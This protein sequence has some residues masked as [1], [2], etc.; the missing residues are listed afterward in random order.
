MAVGPSFRINMIK[1]SDFDQYFYYLID[2]Y[3]GGS[4][5]YLYFTPS[6]SRS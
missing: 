2:S 6:D 4:D 5:Y 3:Y 1:Y